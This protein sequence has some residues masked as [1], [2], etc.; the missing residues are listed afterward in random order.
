[1]R[2]YIDN[3]KMT[4]ITYTCSLEETDIN[5]RYVLCRVYEY[6][7]QSS[8][9]IYSGKRVEKGVIKI[10]EFFEIDG[11]VTEVMEEPVFYA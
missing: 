4:G 7:S 1:M 8:G 5:K 3:C 11:E 10:G 9:N 6:I 2:K